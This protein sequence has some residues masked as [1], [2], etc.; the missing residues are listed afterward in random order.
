MEH[1]RLY[2]RCFVLDNKIKVI[3]IKCL[4]SYPFMSY[5]LAL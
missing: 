1:V 5:R 2:L 4:V 3:I